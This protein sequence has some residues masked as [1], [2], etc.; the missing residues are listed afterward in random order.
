VPVRQPGP[1]PVPKKAG[2]PPPLATAA[3]AAPPPVEEDL[4][5]PLEFGSSPVERAPRYARRRGFPW[6]KILLLLLVLGG[7]GGAAYWWF[8][9]RPGPAEQSLSLVPGD[10]QLFV[11]VR[12]AEVWKKGTVQKALEPLKDVLSS[13]KDPVAALQK[14]MEQEYGLEPEEIDQLTRVQMDLKKPTESFFIVASKRPLDRRKIVNS[15]YTKNPEEVK[16]NGRVYYVS[17]LGKPRNAVYFVNA[18]ICV[19]GT[20]EQVQKAMTYELGRKPQG[21][22]A[23]AI[24]L[25]A[26]GTHDV[27]V[28]ARAPEKPK[29][30]GATLPAALK[31]VTPLLALETGTVV[32]D[33]DGMALNMELTAHF[34][35]EDAASKAKTAADGL[36]ALG[37]LAVPGMKGQPVGVMDARQAA[38]FAEQLKTALDSI[39]VEQK[40]ADLTLRARL[41][42]LQPFI[43]TTARLFAR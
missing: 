2:G 13:G 17:K 24:A 9:L 33:L 42:D 36:V 21:P 32:L 39:K 4:S 10:A 22:L 38:V 1:P 28:G 12:V 11:S 43:Q 40:G 35:G 31:G 14:E 25:A 37:K 29:E 7:A 8:W 3:A 6:V 5:N 19:A 34:P 27:V 18:N 15:N 41:P 30:L 20:E 26:Q 16:H 23:G